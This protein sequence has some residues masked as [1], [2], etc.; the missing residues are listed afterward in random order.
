[1]EEGVSN[2]PWKIEQGD[3]PIVAVAVHAGHD[4]RPEIA[5]RLAL[6]DADRMR[7]EDPYTGGWTR[8]ADTSVVAERSRFEVD[9]N[10]PREEAVYKG[11][12]DAW[13]LDVWRQPLTEALIEESLKEYDAFYRTLHRLLTGI[14]ERYGRFVVLDLHSYNHRRSGDGPPAD[15]EKN[16]E[17]NVGTGTMDRSRWAGVVDRFIGDLSQY[18]LMGRHL[19]V[20]ENVKFVGRQIPRYIHTNFP[21][22]GCAVAVEFKKFFMDEW[23]G[24]LDADTFD[25]IR[26]GLAS[27]VPGLRAELD[28][29][30]GAAA[31]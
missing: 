20:R 11:P 26:A 29:L 7:E 30:K 15:P 23:T 4:V 9:L 27:T 14:E 31:K 22:S 5:E 6:G 10:R 24:E 21:E 13:G 28:R 25:G 16:P 18:D 17:V 1:M 8:V 2:L 3:G 19:D 12:D